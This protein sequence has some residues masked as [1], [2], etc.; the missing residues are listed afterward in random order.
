MLAIHV[1]WRVLWYSVEVGHLGCSCSSFSLAFSAQANTTSAM[2]LVLQDACIL[3]TVLAG[4]ALASTPPPYAIPSDGLNASRSLFVVQEASIPTDDDRLFA[5][6]LQ[7]LHAR[8]SP[9][10]YR[11][12]SNNGAELW[13]QEMETLFELQLH[14][15]PGS[16]KDILHQGGELSAPI[17]GYVLATNSSHPGPA[18]LAAAGMEGAVVATPVTKASLD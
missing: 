12:I 10:L 14:N 1:Y 18:V 15:A 11:N 17:K 4:L 7:G 3:C 2:R 16:A 6:S 13:L 8:V 9:K 5:Q